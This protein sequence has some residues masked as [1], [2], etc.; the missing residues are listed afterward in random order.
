MR[1]LA[2]PFLVAL[3]LLATAPSDA[4]GAE[5]VGASPPPA[6]SEAT[7]LVP[8]HA[9]R[10][11]LEK[12]TV[13]VRAPA[14]GPVEVTTKYTVA[15]PN[16]RSAAVRVA[17]PLSYE[18]RIDYLDASVAIAGAPVDAIEISAGS[19]PLA[20]SR[21][22]MER[23]ELPADGPLGR[24]APALAFTFDVEEYAAVEL[25]VKQRIPWAAIA[26]PRHFP[27]EKGF[28][29]GLVGLDAWGAGREAVTANI[30]TEP[31]LLGPA[32]WAGP[33]PY[34]YDTKGLQWQIAADAKGAIA[35][36]ERFTIAVFADWA[37]REFAGA[38]FARFEVGAD[39]DYLWDHRFF[40][41]APVT[42]TEGREV[43][44]LETV[45]GLIRQLDEI[46]QV[47]LARNG[48]RFDD[49]FVQMRYQKEPWY[50]ADATFSE[51]VIGPVEK[52]NLGYARCQ[53]RAARTVQ[54][55]LEKM[56]AEEIPAT[57]RRFKL[58]LEAFRRCDEQHWNPT[59]AR[60]DT[61]R[62]LE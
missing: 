41:A 53:A 28:S 7:C 14:S 49:T 47:I 62:L 1:M 5:L 25:V 13:D 38:Y 61:P 30:V 29:I 20:V 37:T 57:G 9:E 42:R 10:V 16:R 50:K 34:R 18:G 60:R 22:R 31:T 45:T 39:D 27:S 59:P 3:S 58:L 52:W 23:V 43:L 33:T 48:K 44:R 36:P 32:S 17:L 26:Q 2:V 21:D 19:P 24:P 8:L 15:N 35:V 51:D 56:K 46:E 11:T 12:V 4:A 55:A 6:W 54:S 40:H